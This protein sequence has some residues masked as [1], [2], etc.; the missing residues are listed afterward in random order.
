MQIEMHAGKFILLGMLSG[1]PEIYTYKIPVAFRLLSLSPEQND[2]IK[3]ILMII[4]NERNFFTV[5]LDSF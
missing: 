2:K 1:T 3:N 5:Y 4:S